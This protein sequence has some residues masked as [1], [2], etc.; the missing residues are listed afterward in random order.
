M[1]LPP[2]ITRT[3]ASEVAPE[4]AARLILSLRQGSNS[5]EGVGLYSAGREPLLR[6]ATG[7]T[8][9][10]TLSGGSAV[11]WLKGAYGS[12]KTHMFARLLEVAHCQK[13]L[14]SYVQV[15]GKGQGCELHRFEEVYGAIN[16][17][18]ISPEQ[19]TATQVLTNPGC[20]NGWQWLLESWVEA[21]KRQVGAG[22]GADVPSFRVRE[23]VDTAMSQLRRSYG[24]QGSFASALRA[25]S[26]AMLDDDLE[27]AELLLDW[28]AGSDVFKR[29]PEVRASLRTA[30]ILE[31]VSRKNAKALL[32]QLTAFAR[33]RGYSGVLILVDEVENVLQLTPASRRTAYTVLRELIDNADERHGMARTLIYLSGTP[34]LFEGE[35]GIT[36]YEALA[37]RVILPTRTSAPNPAGAV[38][39]LAA[40]PITSED[41]RAIASR[42]VELHAR[43]DGS[44][45]NTAALTSDRFGELMRSASAQSPRLWVRTVVEFLDTLPA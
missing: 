7:L 41:L 21:L 44:A 10:L 15:S 35:K 1:S 34:D 18:C 38:V 3:E 11:R 40:F 42:I 12:G 6:A 33:Y 16:R 32:R 29:G 36:E 20:E 19:A 27:L 43:A 17:N 5:L 4:L 8:R 45:G 25:Y 23:A 37:S 31:V 24:I 30:G 39:D 2:F 28:F 13:W 26:T 22:A 9:D 14:V